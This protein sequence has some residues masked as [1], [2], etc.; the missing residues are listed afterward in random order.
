L[1]AKVKWKNALPTDT[2]TYGDTS[3]PS[4]IGPTPRMRGPQRRDEIL[5]AAAGLYISY[6]PAKTTTRQIAEAVG[7]SQPSL[8]AHFP[9]KDALS[10][11]L[12][13]RSFAILEERLSQLDVMSDQPLVHLEAL[14][15]GYIHY[16]LEEPSAYMIAF[17]IDLE[18]DKE[19]FMSLQEHVGLRA[20]SIFRDKIERLQNLG[21]VRAGPTEIIAQ[22]IWAA[23]HGLCALLLARP[24]FPWAELHTL[25]ATHTQLIVQGARATHD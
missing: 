12:A 2:K 3:G 11:A 10:Y 7:I 15:T 8:Y 5:T 21:F 1:W 17:M 24:L 4:T 25:I 19:T 20:F 13:E 9:T 22:S 23:M 16:A 14:I 18:I 6:G